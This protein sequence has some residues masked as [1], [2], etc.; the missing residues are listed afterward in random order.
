MRILLT[1]LLLGVFAAVP[2]ARA[3]DSFYDVPAPGKR[4]DLG[5]YKLHIHCEGEGGPTVVLD[6]GLGDWSSHWTAVQKL[7]RVEVQV[8]SYDRA[9]YGWSDPG[10]RPRD[11]ARIVSELHSLLQLSGIRPP[12]LLVGHSFGG[13]N[14]RLYASTYPDEVAGLVLVD[15]SHPES[16][17]YQRNEEGTA[18]ATSFANQLMVMY[19]VEPDQVNLPLEAQAAIRDNL[20]HTK[21]LVTSR[22]EYRHLGASVKAL[23]KAPPLGDV[24]L[25][26]LGRGQ[27]QWPQDA[28]GNAREQS[29]QLQQQELARL[30]SRGVYRTAAQ[31]GHHIHL[32]QPELVVDAVRE[33]LTEEQLAALQLSMPIRP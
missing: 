32:D 23:M 25:V 6:A 10:P 13:L 14:M 20:L 29:W 1:A 21:S 30:S 11:S 15:A 18:P 19:P 24:P 31:S 4:V 7:L 33:L 27:R 28:D 8:C 17:P 12:Y 9:G 22:A 5:G 26:V 2:G 3:D 16:L